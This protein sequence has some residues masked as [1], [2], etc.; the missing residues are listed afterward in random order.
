[1][2]VDEEKIGSSAV[3][4]AYFEDGLTKAEISRKTKVP[5]TTVIRIIKKHL[6]KGNTR[7]KVGSGRRNSLDEDDLDFLRTEIEKNPKVSGPKLATMVFDRNKKEVS[8]KTI[9]RAIKTLGY[10]S[11][12]ARKK[13]LLSDKNIQLRYDHAMEWSSWPLNKW[14]TVLFSDETKINLYSSDGH[15]KVWR[16]PN[17]AHD[18]NNCIP[19]V[20]YRGGNIKLWGC[21]SY[22][23][24]GNLHFIDGIMDKHLYKRILSEHLEDS[25]L[26]LNLPDNF[27]FQ[28]DNDPKHT[29][30]Y[31]CDYFENNG[32][33]VLSWPSQSPDM[34]PIEHLW[35]YIKEKLKKNAF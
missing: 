20:K 16:K 21:F 26:K 11:R 34:N 12:V 18:L 15:A 13:P 27:I 7:R 5:R 3:I 31:V 2:Q 10:N 32:I 9:G 17:S 8:A 14:K 23:G 35:A 4:I 22:S 30:Q 25:R 6:A 19:T 33:N 28:Q 1:M 29:S 24:V